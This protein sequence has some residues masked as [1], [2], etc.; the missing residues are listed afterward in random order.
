MAHKFF[1]S[2]GIL[3]AVFCLGRAITIELEHKKSNY[4]F[5]VEVEAPSNLTGSYLISGQKEKN[6][7]FRVNCIISFPCQF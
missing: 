7:K 2:L 1:W 5:T 6:V 4:C 3:F